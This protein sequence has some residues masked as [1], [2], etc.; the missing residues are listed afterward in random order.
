MKLKALYVFVICK[1]F[2][3]SAAIVSAQ[4]ILF[5]E[6]KTFE[7]LL[8]QARRE[9]KLIF[10]DCYTTWCGPCKRIAAEVFPREEVGNYFN[11]KFINAKFDMEKGEG[12]SI[13]AEFGVRAYPTLLWVNADR[14]VVHRV[15][16]MVDPQTL[17]A[18]GK[19]AN[20]Q[21]PGML[22]ELKAKYERGERSPQ[23]L[24][25]YVDA[26]YNEGANYDKEF[27]EWLEALSEKERLEERN[28]RDIFL[29]I[30]HV[31][32]PGIS[33]L[34]RQ[35]ANFSNII[36]EKNLWSKMVLLAEK[37]M[38]ESIAKKDKTIFDDGL[39]L[40]SAIGGPDADAQ[41]NKLQME[42]AAR[43][44]DWYSYDKYATAYIRKSNNKDA[45]VLNEIAWNY[46]LNVSDK[47]LL[48]KAEKWAYEAVNLKNTSTH[49]LTYAYLLY[50][51]GNI[52]EAIK[53]CDYAILRAKEERLP[54]AGAE[55]L[56][57][58]LQS[59]IK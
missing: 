41:I 59:E 42:Y 13:A 47:K 43:N 57:K 12:I 23:F 30:N 3:F 9:Q 19:Q 31:R 48:K 15:V 40:L 37:S 58:I 27:S 7:Q 29:F 16:G 10:I 52:K 4:G 54:T 24:R 17:I 35:K 50:K 6:G 2:T 56:K 55:E 26:L 20:N 45:V 14:K 28:V 18:A 32:S 11:S 38:K 39:K 34:L 49:N 8:Q 51:N 33:I 36:G 21:M 5:E 46:Y 22:A 44:N 53:A 1:I 25:D